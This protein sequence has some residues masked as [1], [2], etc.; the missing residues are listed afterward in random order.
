M[1]VNVKKDR[2]NFINVILS[3]ISLAQNFSQKV[4]LTI[5][6]KKVLKHIMLRFYLRRRFRN[7]FLYIRVDDRFRNRLER[8]N[9][10]RD[11]KLLIPN[12]TIESTQG[13]Y[14]GFILELCNNT[15]TSLIL[16]LKLISLCS[17]PKDFY[18]KNGTIWK[19]FYNYADT[20]KVPI[21]LRFTN[22]I[23]SQ[24]TN[25]DLIE[26]FNS[27]LEPENDK[28]SYINII[29]DIDDSIIL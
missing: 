12:L 15:H 22:S 28:K 13:H 24:L 16:L 26:L 5:T 7:L 9:F 1:T 29:T 6:K 14:T 11:M 2:N 21:H 3:K 17:R 25:E 27:I 10:Y 20:S 4:A 18:V 8:G 23:L 19:S